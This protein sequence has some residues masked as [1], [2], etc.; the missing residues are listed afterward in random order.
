[1]DRVCVSI[2]EAAKALGVSDSH[3]RRAIKRGE[4]P[5]RQILGRWVVPVEA[6][7]YYGKVPD[8]GS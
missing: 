8:G 3:L 5:A 2:E 1:M 7:L 6:V 4:F